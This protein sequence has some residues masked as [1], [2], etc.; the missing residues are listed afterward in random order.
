MDVPPPVS[1][2]ARLA[3]ATLAVLGLLGGWYILLFGGFEHGNKYTREAVH[4]SGLPA[5]LMAAIFFLMATISIAALLQASRASARWYAILCGP[6]LLSP[7]LYLLYH[8]S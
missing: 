6:A 8:W 1:P 3:M 4:V 7:V 2:A 5:Y